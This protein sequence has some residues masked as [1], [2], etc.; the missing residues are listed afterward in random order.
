MRR[1]RGRAASLVAALTLALLLGVSGSPAHAIGSPPSAPAIAKLTPSSRQLAVTWTVPD[2][3]GSLLI[4]YQVEV[5]T[6]E[7]GTFVVPSAGTCA[8][9]VDALTLSCTITDLVNGT[10]YYVHVIAV[11]ANGPSAAS[12]AAWGTPF[13]R[14]DKTPAPVVRA[15]YELLD[16]T[17]AP[18]P[19]DGGSSITGYAVLIRK[20]RFGAWL[21]PTSGTCT[22]ALLTR[23]CRITSLIG[24]AEYFVRIGVV[25]LAGRNLSAATR[26]VPLAKGDL[27]LAFGGDVH[28]SGAASAQAGPGGLH[29]LPAIFAGADLAMVNLE[30]A[31]TTSGSPTPKEF[32]F[33][34]G[35]G[36]LRTLA[37]AGVDVVTIANNHG[38]DYGS[39]GLRQTLAARATSPVPIVGV[40][41][42][43]ADAIKPYT[44]TVK[45]TSVAFFGI[46]GLDLV[47]EENSAVARSWP[48]TVDGP[49]LAVWHNHSRAIL[50]TVRAWST[51]VD[52]VVVYVHWGYEMAT[53]PNSMQRTV[54]LSLARAGADV[55]VGS[56][57]HVL[58]GAGFMGRSVVAY[59]LGNFAWYSIAGR[60]SAALMVKVH[61]G[62]AA[63]YSWRPTTYTDAGLPYLV[64]GQERRD[65]LSLLAQR[66][67]AQC[68]HLSPVSSARLPLMPLHQST[69]VLPLTAAEQV[70]HP[71]LE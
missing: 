5:A 20:G 53:C 65:T 37:R 59:S 38:I 31:I 58:Q 46:V 22:G 52:V 30:T 70:P 25:N 67:T 62:R 24:G 33:H 26:A 7:G 43:T 21:A 69:C 66:S 3:G 34:A 51:K 42:N 6:S 19:S 45:G 28:F 13:T 18:S 15:G 63:S 39:V 40:G 27:T 61:A 14:A 10:T 36:V 57:P 56:H 68:V 17:W 55:I 50:A 29:T 71:G 35:P 2:D 64:Q 8:A 32:N 44:T 49:G 16:L 1:F 47:Y 12:L 48:A 23:S 54:A 9:A 4:G 11:N 60:P 41:R